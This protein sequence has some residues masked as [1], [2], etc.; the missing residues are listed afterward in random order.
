MKKIARIGTVSLILSTLYMLSACQQSIL[1]VGRQKYN[2]QAGKM[3]GQYSVKVSNS[4][5]QSRG[6]SQNRGI[7]G[8]DYSGDYS[9]SLTINGWNAWGGQPYGSTYLNYQIDRE[10]RLCVELVK[11]IPA[12][13]ERNFYFMVA[14]LARCLNLVISY[15]NPISTFGYRNLSS[16][17]QNQWGYL[18]NWHLPQTYSQYSSSGAYYWP[19]SS[20]L[21]SGW[22]GTE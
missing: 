20:Y 21:G 18:N 1:E 7:R 19:M 5:S 6:V 17:Y 8:V 13:S 12:T 22:I 11:S 2:S 14:T 16:D 10:A 3:L 4:Y 9:G 15:R